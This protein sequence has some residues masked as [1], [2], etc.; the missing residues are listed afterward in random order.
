[1]LQQS[2]VYVLWGRHTIDVQVY[3]CSSDLEHDIS[4]K[5]DLL[6]EVRVVLK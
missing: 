5:Y 3:V 6:V 4:S 1:M 2:L